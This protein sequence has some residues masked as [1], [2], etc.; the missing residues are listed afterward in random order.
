MK[1]LLPVLLLLLVGCLHTTQVDS[2]PAP[3]TTVSIASGTTGEVSYKCYQ[4]DCPNVPESQIE[5]RCEFHNELNRAVGNTSVQLEV[6]SEASGNLMYTGEAVD[7]GILPAH[8]DA[9][10]YT[11]LQR[12]DTT[13]LCGYNLER[14]NVLVVKVPE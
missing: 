2:I 11:F 14:C 10:S 4:L 13:P 6:F 7:S 5:F 9:I 8:E 12:V 3:C 1:Y